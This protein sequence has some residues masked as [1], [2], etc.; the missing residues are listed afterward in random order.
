MQKGTPASYVMPVFCEIGI[1]L[2]C[3]KAGDI[4]GKTLFG[5][6]VISVNFGGAV[7]FAEIQFGDFFVYSWE[8][9]LFNHLFL[10]P[11]SPL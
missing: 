10:G 3:L 11:I 7:V 9:F 6:G 1:G 8:S 4:G 2:I 5:Y